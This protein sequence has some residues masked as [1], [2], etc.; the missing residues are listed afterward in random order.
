MEDEYVR[1]IEGA[2]HHDKGD[3]VG[4]GGGHGEKV[5]EALTLQHLPLFQLLVRRI[6]FDMVVVR[7]VHADSADV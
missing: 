5:P 3:A 4:D 6:P 2:A 7:A 1:Q